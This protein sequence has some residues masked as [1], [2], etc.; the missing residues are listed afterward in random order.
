MEA[1]KLCYIGK[2]VDKKIL[3]PHNRGGKGFFLSYALNERSQ[4]HFKAFPTVFLSIPIVFLAFSVVHWAANTRS[5]GS[6]RMFT[7][8]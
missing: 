6:E 7:G 5:L 8:Q 4:L 3:C 2:F 1:M